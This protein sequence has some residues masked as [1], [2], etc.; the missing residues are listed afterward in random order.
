MVVSGNDD[1]IV[2]HLVLGSSRGVEVS[3]GIACK[4]GKKT[5]EMDECSVCTNAHVV[6]VCS[7]KDSADGLMLDL[8]PDPHRWPAVGSHQNN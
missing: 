7:G 2:A 6:P 8:H 4:C 3:Q 5:S 1:F